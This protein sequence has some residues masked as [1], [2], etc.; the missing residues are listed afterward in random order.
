[1]PQLRLVGSQKPPKETKGFIPAPEIITYE[2]LSSSDYPNQSDLED[3]YQRNIGGRKYMTG[4]LRIILDIPE[5]HKQLVA[6]DLTTGSI[7]GTATLSLD[8][9]FLTH[10]RLKALVVDDYYR[11][12]RVAEKL[13]NLAGQTALGLEATSLSCDYTNFDLHSERVIG[14]KDSGYGFDLPLNQSHDQYEY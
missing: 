10:A 14:Q 13:F 1:M 8:T 12:Y 3:L 2:L 5:E 4:W 9:P 7:I 11:A 6:Q